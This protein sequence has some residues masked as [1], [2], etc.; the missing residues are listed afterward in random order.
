MGSL[1]ITIDCWDTILAESRELDECIDKEI[2]DWLAEIDC[3]I[4][5]DQAGKQFARKRKISPV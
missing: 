5:A 2:V 4:T 3:K 1:C